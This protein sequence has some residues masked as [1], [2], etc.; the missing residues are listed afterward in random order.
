MSFGHMECRQEK[1]YVWSRYISVVNN[2]HAP[3]PISVSLWS[4]T[5]GFMHPVM[6]LAVFKIWS[7]PIL[8]TW[9][10]SLQLFL[11]PLSRHFF[12]S[13]A[14]GYS[15]AKSHSKWMAT[16]FGH[17]WHQ[18][19]WQQIALRWMLWWWYAIYKPP[20]WFHVLKKYCLNF[21]L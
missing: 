15:V 3:L 17:L 18:P 5:F 8:F 13:P 7:S 1:K 6:H 19:C 9:S 4:G 21:I 12:L 16:H 2:T 10:M 14:S 11:K 20:D